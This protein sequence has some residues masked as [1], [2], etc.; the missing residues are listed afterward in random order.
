MSTPIKCGKS[1][2]SPLQSIL[3]PNLLPGLRNSSDFASPQPPNDETAPPK[4]R[5]MHCASHPKTFA[6][7]MHSI[8]NHL[9]ATYPG[10]H[11]PPLWTIAPL[12]LAPNRGLYIIQDCCWS[13]YL[14]R[15]FLRN[16]IHKKIKTL[17]DYTENYTRIT[18][19]KQGVL[20]STCLNSPTAVS[21]SMKKPAQNMNYFGRCW[22]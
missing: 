19:P 5:G 7:G 21:Q 12:S 8:E 11:I 17:T 14:S 16:F 6:G 1:C 10:R 15:I 20:Y 22:K 2:H 18:V 4:L 13:G 3:A 9:T